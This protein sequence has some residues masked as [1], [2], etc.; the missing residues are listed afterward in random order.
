MTRALFVTWDGADQDYMT[1]LFLPLLARAQRPGLKLGVCQLTWAG[2]KV[3]ERTAET[4]RALG[5]DYSVHTI[6]RKPPLAATMATAARGAAL[7]ARIAREQGYDVLFPRSIMP[8]AMALGAKRLLGAEVRLAFDADGLAADERVDFAG[9]RNSGGMYQAYR[10]IEAR[11]LRA[12]YAVM[13]RTHSAAQVLEARAG[14]GFDPARV[15]VIPNGKDAAIYAPGDE[16]S[17]ARQRAAESVPQDAP[18]LVCVGSLG[19]QYYPDRML[20]LF[21]RVWTRD[22]RARL[23]IATG[24]AEVVAPLI[25]G[26]PWA[27]AVRIGRVAPADVP[28]LMAA[29]TAS[30][31]LRAPTFSQRGVHPIKVAESLLCGTPVIA[32]R[33]VGDL[34]EALDI[35][36]G[37]L[38]DDPSDA[39]LDA[40]ARWVLEVAQPER[41]ALRAACRAR[42]LERYDLDRC[43]DALAAMLSAR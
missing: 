22:A 24:Q 11:A 34:D 7:L 17:R 19:P 6:W 8:A 16:T 10:I 26:K 33:G 27:D 12:S 1:S 18:W 9:W 23:H 5:V 13:T 28:A 30:V 39:S 29:A 15:H 41:E 42:G 43:A 36:V 40:A 3:R 14:A 37:C 31:A 2:P 25:A 21:E 4:A 20:A 35:Q 38:L 32:T